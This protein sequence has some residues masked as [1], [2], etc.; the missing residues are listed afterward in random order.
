M[1][2]ILE[3]RIKYDSENKNCSGFNSKQKLKNSLILI[4]M[5]MKRPNAYFLVLPIELVNLRHLKSALSF[6]P[7]LESPEIWL[8]T[9]R[10]KLIELSGYSEERPKP[11]VSL[12]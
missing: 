4:L 2:Y 3:A 10:K 12:R 6:S 8:K 1:T 5:S 11:K 7:N 9:A